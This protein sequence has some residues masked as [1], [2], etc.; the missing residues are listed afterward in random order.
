MAKFL[1][2]I[3]PGCQ[4]HIPFARGHHWSNSRVYRCPSMQ[5]KSVKMV[6]PQCEKETT[7]Q[8]DEVVTESVSEPT[9]FNELNRLNSYLQF[10]HLPLVLYW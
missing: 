5:F 6:C 3:C 2:L 9:D 10:D 8:S 4:T 7:F 1:C